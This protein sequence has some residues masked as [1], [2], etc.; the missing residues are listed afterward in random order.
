M[1]DS[2]TGQVIEGALKADE[3]R[4]AIVASRWNDFIV[5]RLIDGAQDALLRLG[6]LETN[7]T[8]VRVPGSFEIPLAAKKMAASGRYDAIICVG[9]VIRGETPHFD[10]I[11]AGVTNGMA[12]ASLDTGVPIAYGIITADTVEQAINRAGVKAGNKGFEAAMAAV[13]MA[14]LLKEL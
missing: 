6:A 3:L 1:K 4:I 12:A 9:A 14:N 8:L 11:A 7:L 10:Y 2:P 13:E 5:S